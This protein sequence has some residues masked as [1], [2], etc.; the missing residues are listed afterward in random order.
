ML[1]QSRAVSARPTCR[2]TANSDWARL[3]ALGCFPLS[4][5][6]PQG[7]EGKGQLRLSA[8]ETP[9]HGRPGEG[10]VREGGRPVRRPRHTPDAAPARRRQQ[11]PV[12]GAAQGAPL[13][14]ADH[15]GEDGAPEAQ[16]QLP[17]AG[18]HGRPGEGAVREGGRPV[19]RPPA[20]ARRCSRTPSP[21]AP[22][23]PSTSTPPGTR[24]QAAVGRSSRTPSACCKGRQRPLVPDIKPQPVHGDFTTGP[25]AAAPPVRTLQMC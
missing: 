25:P 7:R 23:R 3:G 13:Q 24:R 1:A 8:S 15:P 19:R 9:V 21:T 22:G 14:R 16:R 6:S 10:A 11:H 4:S 5:L 2:R 20:H 17:A 12:G 18:V